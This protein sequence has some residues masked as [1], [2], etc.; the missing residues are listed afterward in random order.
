LTDAYSQR[1]EDLSGPDPCEL[2][3]AAQ[4]IEAQQAVGR[5]ATY[6][7]NG[8]AVDPITDLHHA[9][10][11]SLLQKSS[12]E[13]KRL[14]VAKQHGR[15]IAAVSSRIAA[16]PES[17]LVIASNASGSHTLVDH[18]SLVND[19]RKRAR[20]QDFGLEGDLPVRTCVRWDWKGETTAAA[21][22]CFPDKDDAELPKHKFKCRVVMQGSDVFAG[23]RALMEAGIMTGPLPHYIKDA[24][25]LGEGGTIVVDNGAVRTRLDKPKRKNC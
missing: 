22:A 21:K 4:A 17:P 15:K 7:A 20:D 24:A 25:S 9:A 11:S 1:L 13:T 2:L 23:M 6:A 19:S 18:S 16:Q 8:K 5:F 3:K 10:T 12:K 14:A